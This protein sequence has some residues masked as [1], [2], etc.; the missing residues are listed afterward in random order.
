LTSNRATNSKTAAN[1]LMN[2]I[3]AGDY[4]SHQQNSWKRR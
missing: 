3:A 2:R 1:G 4:R